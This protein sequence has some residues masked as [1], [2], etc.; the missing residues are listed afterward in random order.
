A[1]N[2][3]GHETQH[4][5]D[6]QQNPDAEQT[7]TY[8]D[9]REEYAVIMGDATE[10]YLG[11]NFAQNDTS[12]ADGNSHNWGATTEE[13]DR[14]KA[15]VNENNASFRQE[16]EQ[17]L[18]YYLTKETVDKVK[19][20]LAGATCT[21]AEQKAAVV[22]DAEDLS[23][24]LDNELN[25]VCRDNPTSDACRTSVNTATQYI[26]MED[27]WDI[28]EGD[29]SRS[30]KNTF[31]Y[32]Y[33]SDGAEENF[34]V[35]Y[36]TID[37]RTNFFGASD[38]YE[39]N[40]GLGGKWFGSAEFVSRAAWTGLGADE[41]GS[42]ASFGAGAALFP[43]TY[44][45][46]TSS[47]LYEW[48]S[49]AGNTLMNAG[50]DNFKSLYNQ[51]VS[52][53]VAWDINQLQGEQ[54]ALQPVHEKYLGERTFFTGFSK[55]ITNTDNFIN[56]ETLPWGSEQQGQPGGIDILDQQSRI[57]FGCKLMGYSESQGCKP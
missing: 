56:V 53:P 17:A 23:V 45:P 33:N 32:V 29:V 14:N 46:L 24:M 55:F 25:N 10:D 51:E 12:L 49:E 5:L 54:Q 27:A 43:S 2:T 6:N 57:K 8:H 36:N 7:E 47:E 16:D 35:Y 20:C 34:D 31:D 15:L 41:N 22:A 21:T 3:V 28:L 39:Q 50:F 13:R 38:Q 18:D 19:D 4:Y 30:S 52:D 1:V 9:N 42:W 37:N 26:G 48:R 11:F 40:I 44:N